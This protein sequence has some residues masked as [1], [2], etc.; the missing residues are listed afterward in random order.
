[1]RDKRKVYFTKGHGEVNDLQTVPPELQG[2]I[3]PRSISLLRRRLGDLHYEIKELAPMDLAR[4]VPDDATIVMVLA[5]SVEFQPA[6]WDALD[7]YV[8]R[9]GKLMVALDPK[10]ALGMGSLETRLGTR[11]QQGFL[12][13][14]VAFMPQGTGSPAERRVVMTSQFTAHATTTAASRG[15]LILLEAG[16]LEEA[17][18]PATGAKPKR[19]V[20][21]RS[22]DTAWVDYNEN[23][24]LD[25]AGAKPEKKQRYDLGVVLEGPKI[26]DKD[27]FRAV[28][29]ADIDL[30]ADITARTRMGT[31]ML[32]P[33]GHLLIDTVRWLGGEEVFA[34]EIVSEDD[35]PI[36]HTK[37]EDAVWFTLTTVGAPL[38][39][40]TL[41]LVG[42]WARRRRAKKSEVTL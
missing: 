14:A 33:G 28:V 5:P 8:A 20:T 6:E 23:F 35:K 26:G 1:V 25:A 10:G 17:P 40:L 13:D 3:E 22:M 18:F 36:K 39:V 2:R 11:M 37:N 38:L 15:Q 34:G 29:Y 12:T 9:G 19:T 27:G 41:G 24:E 31:Q 4:D 21:I 32:M 7:R 16:A 42:T 30:F